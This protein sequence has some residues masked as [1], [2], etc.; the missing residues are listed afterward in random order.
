MAFKTQILS[1]LLLPSNHRLLREP[2]WLLHHQVPHELSLPPPITR[3]DM[4]PH[5]YSVR[6]KP[7]DVLSPKVGGNGK[8]PE[9]V[10][11]LM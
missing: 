1:V 5:S 10:Q 6:E 8:T 11:A 9:T 3:R 7:R 2:L 4:S